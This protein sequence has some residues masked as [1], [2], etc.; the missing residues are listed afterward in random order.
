MTKKKNT[1]NE[2]VLLASPNFKA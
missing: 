1:I 2:C